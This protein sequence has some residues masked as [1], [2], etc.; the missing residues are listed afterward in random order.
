M[1][2]CNLVSDTCENPRPAFW[3][4]CDFRKRCELNRLA[5]FIHAN[6]IMWAKEIHRSRMR[7]AAKIRI[8]SRTIPEASTA[9]VSRLSAHK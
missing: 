3:Y 4:A 5:R 8:E 7:R 9:Y 6:G 1:F 2:E